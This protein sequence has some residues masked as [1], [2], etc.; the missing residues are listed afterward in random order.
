MES[1]REIIAALDEGYNCWGRRGIHGGEAG[2][3]LAGNE[4]SGNID[5]AKYVFLTSILIA[6][7]KSWPIS[8]GLLSFFCSYSAYKILSLHSKEP[9]ETD[10]LG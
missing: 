10:E 2:C 4:G 8:Y 5:L 7:G 6:S 9:Y 3:L 1:V